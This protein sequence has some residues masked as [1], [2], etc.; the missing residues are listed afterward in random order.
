MIPVQFTML[1]HVVVSRTG[2]NLLQL[3]TMPSWMGVGVVMPLPG[4]VV[5]GGLF[6]VVVVV[7]G[8]CCPVEVEVDVVVG[9]GSGW[10]KASTQYELKGT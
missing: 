4:S 5:V 2:W 9:T 3:V 8:G 1:V 6:V 10:W 7:V